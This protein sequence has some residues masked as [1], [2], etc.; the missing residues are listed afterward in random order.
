MYNANGIREKKKAI[1]TTMF[2][3][4]SFTICVNVADDE[5][6]T[7]NDNNFDDLLGRARQLS[8]K[9]VTSRNQ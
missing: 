9:K 5:I 6:S 2:I 7:N 8:D 4:K 1:I 3:I